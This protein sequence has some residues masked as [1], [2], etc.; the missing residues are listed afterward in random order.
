[1]VT[2]HKK[3]IQVEERVGNDKI[4]SFIRYYWMSNT[5]LLNNKLYSSISSQR[6]LS[7]KNFLTIL[8][9]PQKYMKQ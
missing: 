7:Y 2:C 9:K 1:M 5:N 6:G 8:I 4:T 3:W